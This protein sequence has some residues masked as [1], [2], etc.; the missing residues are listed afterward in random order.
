L[1]SSTPCN[2]VVFP[3]L[4]FKRTFIAFARYQSSLNQ[5]LE[6]FDR[7]VAAAQSGQSTKA[8][9]D[10]IALCLTS[11]VFKA[12]SRGLFNEHKNLFGLTTALK[13]SLSLGHL[14]RNDVGALLGVSFGS[15]SDGSSSKVPWLKAEQWQR[16]QEAEK[17]SSNIRYAMD[18]ML[19]DSTPWKDWLSGDDLERRVP[20]YTNKSPLLDLI[21]IRCVREDRTMQAVTVTIERMLGAEFTQ[22]SVI[23]FIAV[24]AEVTP[25]T[26]IVFLLSAGTDPSQ[27]IES[28]ARKKRIKLTIVSMGQGQ[29]A[30]AKAAISTSRVSGGWVLLQNGHLGLPLMVDVVS[31]LQICDVGELSSEFRLWITTPPHPDFPISLLHCAIKITNQPPT[32]LQAGMRRTL[33]VSL[34]CRLLF[35]SISD[36]WD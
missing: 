36:A 16:L 25:T 13:I 32:G 33:Q 6:L 9:V 15:K 11:V 28:A 31:L 21:L 19:Q 4:L 7:S 35:H 22:A 29:E 12:V 24:A 27:Q 3:S 5:F 34:G 1:A 23:D 17:L 26:P 30:A 2:Y 18:A 14:D 20:S 10:N 8:R